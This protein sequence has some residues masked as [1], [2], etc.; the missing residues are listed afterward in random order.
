M[1]ALLVKWAE[2]VL[3]I[4]ALFNLG[5]GGVTAPLTETENDDVSSWGDENAQERDTQ[6]EQD[7]ELFCTQQPEEE[8]VTKEVQRVRKAKFVA[9]KKPLLNRRISSRENVPKQAPAQQRKEPPKASAV[10]ATRKSGDENIQDDDDWSETQDPDEVR[11]TKAKAAIEQVPS[12]PSLSRKRQAEAV[13]TPKGNE[14]VVESPWKRM[15]TRQKVPFTQDEADAI[16]EGVM[17]F[18]VGKWKI[19]KMSDS[20]LKHRN[21][22]QIKDKFR[23]MLRTGE[24]E[25]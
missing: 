5:Y 16:R 13:S 15:R 12:P 19:I 14:A 10:A 8:I 9:E 6:M 21:P 17:R 1:H 18:G 22:V 2:S 11:P 23:N 7:E 25:M 4:P 3:E 24:I 20:R